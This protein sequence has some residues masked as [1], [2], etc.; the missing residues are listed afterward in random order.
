MPAN[1]SPASPSSLPS[2]AL[3]RRLSEPCRAERDLQADFLLHLAEFDAR[4]AYLEA[5]YGSLWSYCMEALHLVRES[6]A[7]RR[8]R[9]MKVLRELPRL[10]PALGDGRLGLTTLGMLG[11]LL[12]S[13]S[14]SNEPPSSPRPTSRSSSCRFSR[15]RHA[16]GC[17]GH[18]AP[19]TPRP[20]QSAR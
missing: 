6:A 3:A 10:E 17:A 4:H 19:R 9:A 20:P 11:P 15:G 14:S 13:T 12:T 16:M 5:G 7:G 2:S 8:T 18:R 1:L